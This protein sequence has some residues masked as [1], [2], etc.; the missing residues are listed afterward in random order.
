M[1]LSE[2]GSRIMNTPNAGGNSVTS[3][4]MSFE[5]L[6]RLI[7]ARLAKTEM[8]IPYDFPDHS[9]KT[10]Y[11]ISVGP[12]DEARQI[13]IS[14]TRA[15]RAP[16]REYEYEHAERLINKKLLCVFFSSRNVLKRHRWAQQV[17]HILT[18]D[19]RKARLL[20]KAFKRADPELKQGV[21]VIVTVTENARFLYMKDGYM[22][23]CVDP[24][25]DSDYDDEHTDR[26]L[27]VPSKLCVQ[28]DTHW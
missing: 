15:M 13:A 12:Q 6:R 19:L 16:G 7:G 14:V 22:N 28:T 17:L 3:E 11:V 10:D 25:T 27:Y 18:D 24:D 9:K 21:V 8:E 5:L 1:Q 2:G 4:V 26:V 20:K 23:Q